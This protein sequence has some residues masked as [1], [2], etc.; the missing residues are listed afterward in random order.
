[1][2]SRMLAGCCALAFAVTLPAQ[3]QAQEKDKMMAMHQPPHK[4]ATITGTVIDVSC[5]FGQGLTGAE[6]KMC[7]G[8]CSDKGIPLAILSD[9]GKLYIPT[10]PNM[11]G[12]AQ[13][14]KLKPFAEQK[15]TVSGDVFDAGGAHAIQ[16]N[17]IKKA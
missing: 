17:S 16:I 2:L 1:M 13:N 12:D 11:P 3:L 6:H 9:D 15:V 14:D 10:S 4:A 5:K 7:A 8:V